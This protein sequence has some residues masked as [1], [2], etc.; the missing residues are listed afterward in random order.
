MR[1]TLAL[2]LR[3][4]QLVLLGQ[5]ELLPI[6][7]SLPNVL[8]RISLTITSGVPTLVVQGDRDPF[9]TPVAGPQCTLVTVSGDHS[10]RHGLAGLRAFAA[11]VADHH[12][13]EADLILAKQRNGPTGTVTVAFQGRY[14]RFANM[15]P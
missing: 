1:A 13:A 9:G 14:S 5:M 7:T 10:L 2:L 12:G 6:L 15:K 4:L 3:L 11:V 8:D